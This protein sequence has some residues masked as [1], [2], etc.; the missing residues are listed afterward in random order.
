MK[1]RDDLA[2][3]EEKIEA[4][5]THLAV[6]QRVAPRHTEPVALNFVGSIVCPG[7][8]ILAPENHRVTV[9]LPAIAPERTLRH[10]SIE[11]T[12][13]MITQVI[14]M[15]VSTTFRFP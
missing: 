10:F 2:Q 14:M 15:M 5:L 8:L 3:G 6:G 12:R 13:M 1:S 9:T 11:S 7:T 4:F